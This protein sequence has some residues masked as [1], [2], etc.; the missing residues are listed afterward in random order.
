MSIL[1]HSL[2]AYLITKNS[3]VILGSIMPDI[4]LIG[5]NK[6]MFQ[7]SHNIFLSM[8]ITLIGK[9]I[10]IDFLMWFGV[11]MFLHI[12][13]DILQHPFVSYF[14]PLKLKRNYL[15]NKFLEKLNI[16]YYLY[17]LKKNKN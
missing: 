2:I 15:Y 9:I 12:L 16:G 13:V 17:K 5:G 10:G 11:G 3:F 6:K 14:L 8:I 4:F 7:I 1:G